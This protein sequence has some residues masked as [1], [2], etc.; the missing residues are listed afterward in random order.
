MKRISVFGAFFKIL[1]KFARV[2]PRFFAVWL[3]ANLIQGIFYGLTAPATQLFL[4]RVVAFSAHQA[5]LSYVLGGLLIFGAANIIKHVANG[6]AYFMMQNYY[7][8]AEGVFSLD[9]HR[10]ARRIAPILFEDTAFLDDMNKTIPGI[11][12]S[13]VF[14]GTVLHALTFYLPCYIIMA[15]YLLSIKPLL[16]V[17]LPLI[18][19]PVLLTQL[20]RTKMF[21]NAED[22]SAPVRREL[23]YYESCM[24][25][26]EYFKETR[27]LGAL[28][29]FK[30]FYNDSL[31]LLNK[32]SFRAALKTDVVEMAA[33]LLS[34]CGYAGIVLLLFD[35]LMKGE[36]GVASFAA[37]NGALYALFAL[38]EEM[39]HG[40]I[41]R[42][43]RDF[44]Q[45]RNYLRF[46]QMQERGGVDSDIPANTDISLQ[47]VSFSYRRDGQHR[48]KA[49]DNVSVTIKKGETVAVVGENGS[50]KTTLVRLFT[51]IYLPDEGDILYGEVNTK[52]VSAASLF[53]NISAVFQ[54]YQRYQMTL[55]ENIG[56]SSVK[57]SL[58]DAALNEITTQAGV[59]RTASSFTNGY[60]TMLSREFDGVDLSGGQWQRIA[61][62]R[63]LFRSHDMIVLDEPTA[64]IDPVEETRIYEQFAEI[65]RSKTAIIVTHRLGS[66]KLADKILVMKRGRL[67]EQ[68]KHE[69][70]I[71]ANGEYARL[72]KAQ[73]QWYV[74]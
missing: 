37:V 61:I 7:R 54:K 9:V 15:V 21:A 5:E 3:A 74:R 29:Y 2:A 27:L 20:L 48:K 1:P 19:I 11:R 34:L 4:N 14:V 32:I 72:Y 41:G 71:A 68:G 64:A 42:A 50:G 28:A 59:D 39:I 40:Y 8:K 51:G 70:L 62:A 30:G 12:S 16:V 57:S 73:E 18:F 46:M 60:D 6:I 22:E 53:K 63:G 58:D 56:I 24:S 47:G 55:R 10:K 49:V 35:G 67:V 33:K 38:T 26:R 44:G 66:A 52:A 65:S 13:A 23:E 43:A 31:K 69:E 36:V 17:S 25:G 45:V